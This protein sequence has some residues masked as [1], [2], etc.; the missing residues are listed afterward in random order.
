MKL[1]GLLTIPRGKT[2]F[3]KIIVVAK[4]AITLQEKENRPKKMKGIRKNGFKLI[5]T[6][7]K[8]IKGK[9]QNFSRCVEKANNTKSVER[10][11]VRFPRS[12]EKIKGYAEKI[13]PK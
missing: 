6:E 12:K 1:H 5:A 9:F 2:K 11:H 13:Q 4:S 8:A 10:Y 7:T 3:R